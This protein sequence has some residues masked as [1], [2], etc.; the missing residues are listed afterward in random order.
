MT[1][2]KLITIAELERRCILRTGHTGGCYGRYDEGTDGNPACAQCGGSGECDSGGVTPWD[3]PIFV[4]CGCTYPQVF[5]VVK[6][7]LPT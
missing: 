6:T 3:A 2:G 5:K 7:E 4:R 1:C